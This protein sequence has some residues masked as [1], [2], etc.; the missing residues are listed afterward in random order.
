MKQPESWSPAKHSAA[1][2]WRRNYD[3]ANN[4]V[5]PVFGTEVVRESKSD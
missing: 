5:C 4:E 3:P 1:F 2:E